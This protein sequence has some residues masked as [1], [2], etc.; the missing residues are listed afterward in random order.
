MKKR[1]ACLIGNPNVGKSSI[2]NSLTGS[3]QHTGNW[4]GKTVSNEV[5]EF[6][7]Q[8]TL[9]ELVDLP[10]TYSLM[11]ESAEE[12]I[13][14]DYVLGEDYDLAIVVADATNLER[15][16]EILLEVMDVIDEVL[17]CLNLM[18]EARKRNI[19]IDKEL[20]EKRLGV[21][22]ILT[23]AKEGVGLEEL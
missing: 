2:F 23:S 16:M 5:G 13:A 20:L 1:K 7:Y 17:V 3:L 18:D 19:L 15:S 22:V 6:V 12:K 4:T 9:W 21:P 10:G 11:C 14:S 8:D